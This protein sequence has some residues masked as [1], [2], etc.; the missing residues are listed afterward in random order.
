MSAAE[1]RSLINNENETLIRIGDFVGVLPAITGKVEL[2]Y[3]G[4]QEGSG[5]VANNLVG[6]AIRTL[7]V[8]YFPNP[9]DFRKQKE[10]PNPF[11]RIVDWFGDSNMVD[12]VND[13]TNLEYFEVLKA[14]PGAI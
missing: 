9:D 6:K 10:K 3:E 7:F 2:V 4:E 11:K 14:V 12:L 13:A 1:R 8:D 5:I